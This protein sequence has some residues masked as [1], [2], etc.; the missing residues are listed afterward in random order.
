MSRLCLIVALASIDAILRAQP[1]TVL[2]ACEVLQKPEVYSGSLVR[3]RGLYRVD[4]EGSDIVDTDCRNPINSYGR[5]WTAGIWI[6]TPKPDPH[7]QLTGSFDENS[8]NALVKAGREAKSKGAVVRATFEGQL[9]YCPRYG[10]FSNGRKMW[11]ACGFMGF[12]ILR[13]T[14][15]SVTDIVPEPLANLPKKE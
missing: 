12:Y 1:S 6:T 11:M 10:M 14:V 8:Y 3:V 15:R 5:E 4:S 13:L 2:R 7:A 9:E